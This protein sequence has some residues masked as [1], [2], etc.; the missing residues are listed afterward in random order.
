MHAHRAPASLRAPEK[1]GFGFPEEP[2]R[3]PPQS[4]SILLVR[5]GEQ[6]PLTPPT[7]PGN[8]LLPTPDFWEP[9]ARGEGFVKGARERARHAPL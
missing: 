9:Q 7:A 8:G 2:G 5:V 1:L 6:P 3:P 4:A